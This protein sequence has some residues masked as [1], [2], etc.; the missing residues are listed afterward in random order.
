MEFFAISWHSGNGVIWAGLVLFED[1]RPAVAQRDGTMSAGPPGVDP[2]PVVDFVR[3]KYGPELLVDVAWI[4]EMPGFDRADRPYR[5]SFYDVTLVTRG[6][7]E[8]WID[9]ERYRLAANTLLFSCPGQTRRWIAR[10]LDGLCLFFPDE[11][12]LQHFNDPLFLNRLR[13]FHNDVG[14][15]ELRVSDSRV[16]YL[17]DRLGAMRLEIAQLQY[18]SPHLLR[19]IAYEILVNL[20]R[21]Y[22]SE[23][24]QQLD[25]SATSAVASFRQ[26]V[27]QHFLQH[28]HVHQYADLLGLTPGHLNYLC[29]RHI[30]R[31]AGEIIRGR[32]VAEAKRML[33]YSDYSAAQIGTYLGFE[34]TSYFGRFFRRETDRTP[35]S[36]RRHAR[37]SLGI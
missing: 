17:L 25:T 16:E 12:L 20:N 2:A 36:Y 30:G 22:A 27:E 19:A 23:Y 6:S 21:W 32:I 4:S 34:D 15:F 3:T 37:I 26:L 10:D 1:M 5:L 29:R 7:G 35:L 33:L 18:D 9:A 13:Y 14:P 11:F 24:G 28:K 31:A 8:F